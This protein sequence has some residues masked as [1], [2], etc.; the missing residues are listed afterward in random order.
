MKASAVARCT[1]NSAQCRW[2]LHNLVPEKAT[3]SGAG[4]H[5]TISN[6]WLQHPRGLGAESDFKFETRSEPAG[7][8]ERLSTSPFWS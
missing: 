1:G 3:L 8:A 6:R 4:E 5:P 2:L 7:A